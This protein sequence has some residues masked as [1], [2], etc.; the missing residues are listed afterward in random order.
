M[1]LARQDPSARMVAL[2]NAQPL[3]RLCDALL[4]LDAKTGPDEAER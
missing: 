1:S 2:V 3:D 4:M